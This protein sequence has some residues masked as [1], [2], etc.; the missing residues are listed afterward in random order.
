MRLS[1]KLV[2]CNGN[3]FHYARHRIEKKILASAF[4]LFFHFYTLEMLSFLL[5]LRFN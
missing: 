5:G 1:V 2:C 4:C 3:L